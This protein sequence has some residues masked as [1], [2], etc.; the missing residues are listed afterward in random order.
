[1]NNTKMIAKDLFNEFKETMNVNDFK[2]LY[3]AM[4]ARELGLDEYTEAVDNLMNEVLQNEY[5][6]NAAIPC[7]I[8]YH[9][10][11]AAHEIFEKEDFEIDSWY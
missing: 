10:I 11:D 5:Y 4:V 6:D 1:M 7:F 2:E 3:K 9:I 8:D